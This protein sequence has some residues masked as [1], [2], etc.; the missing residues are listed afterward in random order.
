M[1]FDVSGNLGFQCDLTSSEFGPGFAQG[2][3]G[4]QEQLLGG[5]VKADIRNVLTF[6]P[7]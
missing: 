7:N 5:L 2:F 3:G 6:P 1:V 4:A